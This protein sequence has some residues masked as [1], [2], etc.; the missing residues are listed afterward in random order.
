LHYFIAMRTTRASIP[1]KI[2]CSADLFE[3]R[4]HVG[5]ELC[6]DLFKRLKQ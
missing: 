5:L 4:V 2:L 1:L 3:K 6:T